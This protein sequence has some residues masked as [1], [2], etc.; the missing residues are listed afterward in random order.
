M[1][2]VARG[3]HRRVA[4]LSVAQRDRSPEIVERPALFSEV[5]E[6][7]EREPESE[8]ALDGSGACLFGNFVNRC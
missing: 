8:M 4:D 3:Q 5:S 1:D 2:G 7:R 6:E